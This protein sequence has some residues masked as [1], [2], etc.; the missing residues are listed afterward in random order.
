MK[1]ENGKMRHN[2]IQPKFGIQFSTKEIELCNF[3][4]ISMTKKITQ[5]SLSLTHLTKVFFKIKLI[6]LFE[7]FPT[8]IKNVPLFH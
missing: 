7:G 5:N 2:F 4:Q 1:F 3:I 6:A 8:K